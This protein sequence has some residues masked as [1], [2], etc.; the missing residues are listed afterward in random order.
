MDINKIPQ[1]ANQTFK[2]FNDLSTY[3]G[4]PKLTG[5]AKPAFLKELSLYVKYEQNGRR[6]MIKEV[7]KEPLKPLKTYKKDALW[8]NEAVHDIIINHVI[9]IKNKFPDKEVF[10]KRYELAILVNI[11]N[12][13]YYF[14]RDKYS[15]S[16]DNTLAATN[17]YKFSSEAL[18]NALKT[19]INSLATKNRLQFLDTYSIRY[20]D[21]GEVGYANNQQLQAIME[22]KSLVSIP[23]YGNPGQRRLYNKEVNK[24]L[25]KILMEDSRDFR[26]FNI[27]ERGYQF[28]PLDSTVKRLEQEYLLEGRKH[29]PNSMRKVLME[30]LNKSM[31]ELGFFP[32]FP[33][34]KSTEELKEEYRGEFV[35]LIDS[36]LGI[37]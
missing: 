25:E 14:N 30:K 29:M 36:E 10:L 28:F 18:S 4:K 32:V 8:V 12:E 3:L 37:C 22:A 24:E 21:N 15:C 5:N 26:L 17:F 11:V 23:S 27:V 33:F 31:D 9:E 35:E 2:S 13:E 20:V 1:L 6:I 34:N 7:Y 16:K 19:C